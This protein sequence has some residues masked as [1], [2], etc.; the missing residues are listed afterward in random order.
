M[1][2][3]NNA[4]TEGRSQQDD[5]LDEVEKLLA[6]DDDVNMPAILTQDSKG[7]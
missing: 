3:P 1:R 4:S 6:G 2:Q 7:G 5:H